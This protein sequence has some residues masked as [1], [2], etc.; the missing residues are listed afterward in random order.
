[1][2]ALTKVHH[3]LF[4]D[5]SASADDDDFHGCPLAALNVA[6][7]VSF[8]RL[9]ATEVPQASDLETSTLGPI[10]PMRVRRLR[11]LIQSYIPSSQHPSKLLKSFGATRP[12]LFIN[13]IR[14]MPFFQLENLFHLWKDADTPFLPCPQ[15]PRTRDVSEKPAEFKHL[16]PGR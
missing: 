9:L 4:P 14:M 11:G 7:P 10:S 6:E 12:L 8:S 2:A 13:D 1:M 5:E 3:D 16:H 15:Q